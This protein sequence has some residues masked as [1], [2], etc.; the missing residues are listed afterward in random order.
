MQPAA[1]TQAA[2]DA[3][4]ERVEPLHVEPD[5]QRAGVVVGAGADR[6]AGTRGAKE[7]E[8]IRPRRHRSRGGVELGASMISRPERVGVEGVARLHAAGVRAEGDQQHVDDDQR[9]RHHAG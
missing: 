8:Q 3:E 6:L 5:D 9:D 7:R 1:P 4:G 2:P